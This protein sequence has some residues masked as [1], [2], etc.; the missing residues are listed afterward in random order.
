MSFTLDNIARTLT[1]K[2]IQKIGVKVFGLKTLTEK[3][4]SQLFHRNRTEGISSIGNV[5]G[6]YY[7]LDKL[8]API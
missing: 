2:I 3:Y 6:I 1:L 8:E 7:V 4:N 5:E